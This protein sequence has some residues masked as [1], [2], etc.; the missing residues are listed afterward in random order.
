MA[1]IFPRVEN[2]WWWKST[3]QNRPL[4]CVLRKRYSENIKQIYKRTPMLKF[5][6]NFTENTLWHGYCKFA[7]YFQ[8][9]ISW[10]HHWRAASDH[11]YHYR[12]KTSN[13]SNEPVNYPC[14]I[15]NT[16]Q[17]IF[18]LLYLLELVASR[19]VKHKKLILA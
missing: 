11:R 4:R 12:R 6:S 14:Y 3:T 5:P 17:Q 10:E 18:L 15:Y 2:S 13:C 7:I 16:S 1:C 19:N 8:K 9:T